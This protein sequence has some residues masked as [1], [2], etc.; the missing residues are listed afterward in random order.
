[1]ARFSTTEMLPSPAFEPRMVP[2]MLS[3]PANWKAVF[4]RRAPLVVE[5]GCGG[6]RYLVGQA[7]A[8]RERDF[9]AIELAGT[10]LNLVR[11]RVLKR[12][13]TNMRLFKTDAADLIGS[14]FPDGCVHEYHI[15]FPDPWPK[16]RHHKR[17]LFTPE[18]CATLRR[19]LAP[20][21]TLFFAT[22]YAEYFEE[23]QPMLRA[24][25]R[26][27]P[28]PEPW[29]DAPAGRTNYEI[30]YLLE[31]RPIYRLTART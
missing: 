23:I 3:V 9:V 16:K 2:G 31:G 29:E 28:H 20:D 22:D 24:V 1:M 17:R 30:K 21:A 8:H 14:C 25:L 13:L 5:I 26:V 7:D 12:G 15:Y 18:F 4:G 19:T 27:T 11:K 6:G 10:Y